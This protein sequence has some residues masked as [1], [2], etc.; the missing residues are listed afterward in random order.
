MQG[1]RTR[2]F[3]IPST[4]TL[5]MSLQ[6]YLLL[7]A[8]GTVLCWGAWALV[9]FNLDPTTSGAIGLASFSL[10]LFLALVGTLAFLGFFLRRLLYRKKLPYHHLG[11]SVRQGFFL[12]FVIVGGL[13][14]RGT[15]LY[16]WWSLAL[17]IAGFT[18][19]EFF[20]L[21]RESS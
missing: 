10:S 1:V 18:V 16:A 3:I 12:A 19:L 9:L 11:V 2:I 21:T 5:D 17:L 4:Q 15:G 7:A 6:R 13:L 8:F 14:L 20:F